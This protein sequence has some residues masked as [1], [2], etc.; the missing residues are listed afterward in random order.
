VLTGLLV[1]F[2]AAFG[3]VFVAELG[4]KSQLLALTFST[5]Y[6]ALA[7]LIGVTI[8]AAVM[9]GAAVLIGTVL[10]VSLPTRAISVVAG[11]L[12][13]GFGIWT[14]RG[15]E[16]ESE[17]ELEAE[18]SRTVSRSAVVTIAVSFLIAEF[19]DKTMLATATLAT[20]NDPLGTWL[21]ATAGMVAADAIAIAVGKQLGERLPERAIRIGAGVV[22]I[23]IGLLVLADAWRG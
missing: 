17:E 15:E 14:L 2:G 19:G 23:G 1:A 4:D 12:F 21:G 22:F 3:V 5:R 8:A 18:A 10:R 6:R 16:E 13:I 11:V 9:L 20:K 7:T